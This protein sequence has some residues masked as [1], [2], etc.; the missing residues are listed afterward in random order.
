MSPSQHLQP[1]PLALGTG[2]LGASFG[3]EVPNLA[4]KKTGFPV[5]FE[6]QINDD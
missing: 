6:F 2:L 3:A 4:N 1:Q 5:K